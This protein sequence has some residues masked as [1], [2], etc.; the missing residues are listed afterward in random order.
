MPCDLV[1]SCLRAFAL[2]KNWPLALFILLL[3]LVPYGVNM[4]RKR[5]QPVGRRTCFADSGWQADYGYGLTGVVD[6]L[7]GCLNGDEEP[8]NISIM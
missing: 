6:P 4:V 3:S 2:S 1:F 7:F 5:D 8:L